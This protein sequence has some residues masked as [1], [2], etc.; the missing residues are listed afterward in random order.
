M[1]LI[2]PIVEA[3]E[4]VAG[5]RRGVGIAFDLH[6]VAARR[7]VDAEALLD[8]D[9]V[10]VVIAEQRPKQIGLLELQLEAGA[11][12]RRRRG[13][14]GP[15]G[16]DLLGERAPAMLFGPA[17]TSVTSR[18][19]PGLASVSTWTDWSHGLLP[20]IW[21]S[22]RPLRSIRMCVLIPTFDWLNA[23]LCALIRSCSR[24]SRSSIT[25]RV[26]WSSMV[27]AG[28]P[29]ASA[30]FERISRGVTDLVDDLQRRLEILLGLAREADDEVAGQSDVGAG[31]AHLLQYAKIGLG[32]VAAVHRLEDAVR[33]RLHGKVQIGHQLLDLAM[34]GDQRIVHVGGMTGGVADAFQ[35][36]DPGQRA[37][38][39]GEAA[40]AVAQAFTF[41]PSRTISR[42]PASTSA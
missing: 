5:A 36:I 3:D 10:A 11:V 41:W 13:R 27:A 16:G 12:R 19:S 1:A 20:I 23:R 34:R 9:Q 18:M 38:E 35:P 21:P 26:I 39:L 4:N 28:V 30:I 15:S 42:A 40:R 7:D 2:E 33:S 8:G 22:R 37:D 29:G 25:S 6:L 31:G 14:G 17:A 24:C 32:A